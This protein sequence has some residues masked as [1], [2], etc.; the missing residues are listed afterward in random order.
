[1]RL[2][3]L[4]PTDI[5]LEQEVIHVTAEDV[6]GSLG[7]RPGHTPLVT[8]L[9]RGIVT[10]RA[11]GGGETYV[12]IDGGAMLVNDDVVQIVS[13]QAVASPDLTHLER[14]VLTQFEK[15]ASEDRTNRVAFEKMRLSLMRRVLE[16]ER[17]GEAL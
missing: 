2:R 7:I 12:A 17:A 11:P 4:T 5:V 10:A 3:L 16:F 6:T 14:D 15:Q 9:T 13:R 1:M 8:P